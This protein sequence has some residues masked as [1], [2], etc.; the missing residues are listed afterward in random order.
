[1]VISP[2]KN[3]MRGFD[4]SGSTRSEPMSMPNTRQSVS[5]RMRADRWWPIKPFT[6]RISTLVVMLVVPC[7]LQIPLPVREWQCLGGEARTERLRIAYLGVQFELQQA[8]RAVRA[9]RLHFPIDPSQL[10]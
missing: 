10:C 2:S 3:F 1:M 7:L 4:S 5:L 8:Q 9:D 6:P